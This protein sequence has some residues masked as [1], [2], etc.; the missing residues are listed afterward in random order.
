MSVADLFS[1]VGKDLVLN[2]HLELPPEHVLDAVNRACH[3]RFDFE[4]FLLVVE[5]LTSTSGS[6]FVG[7]VFAFFM[8]LLHAKLLHFLW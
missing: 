1:L 2:W 7:Y 5:C 3:K 8:V 4:I 6:D